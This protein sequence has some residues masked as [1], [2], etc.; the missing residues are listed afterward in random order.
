MTSAS[1]AATKAFGHQPTLALWPSCPFRQP[2][3]YA[4][5]KTRDHSKSNI[6][7]IT[8]SLLAININIL[9]CLD[10]PSTGDASGP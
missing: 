4:H 3:R 7:R 9:K 10:V 5:Q 8:L 2:V 6:S 1:V